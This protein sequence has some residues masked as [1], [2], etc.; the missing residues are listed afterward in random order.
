MKLESGKFLLNNCA[1]VSGCF[2]APEGRYRV[3]HGVS[4]GTRI[5]ISSFSPGGATELLQHL[6]V[7]PSEMK[8]LTF[9]DSR[10]TLWATAPLR[11]KKVLNFRALT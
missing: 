10:L 5:H 7:A 9:K 1:Q 8:K 4:R 6:S 3:A 11:G 2:P